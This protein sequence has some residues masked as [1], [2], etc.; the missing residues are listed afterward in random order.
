M[1][2]VKNKGG[3]VLRETIQ[4]NTSLDTIRLDVQEYDGTF[5]TQFIDFKNVSVNMTKCL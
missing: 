1:V 3:E 2:N 5:I 4:A